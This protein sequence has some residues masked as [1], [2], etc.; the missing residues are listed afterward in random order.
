MNHS[1]LAAEGARRAFEVAE[2]HG[3]RFDPLTDVAHLALA[4][5]ARRAGQLAEAEALLTELVTVAQ[6]AGYMVPRG[7][8]LLE[9]AVVQHD[10]GEVDDA[11]LSLQRARDVVRSCEDAGPLEMRLSEVSSR[12]QRSSRPDPGHG[13]ALT[14][15]ETRVLRMLDTSLSQPEIARELHVSVNTVRTHIQS[16]YR[17]LGVSTRAQAIVRGRAKAGT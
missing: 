9:L 10:R 17:K 2:T 15:V 13:V 11:R 6:H 12:L 7:H 3:L 16:V 4:R 8:A 5:A 1:E 14:T